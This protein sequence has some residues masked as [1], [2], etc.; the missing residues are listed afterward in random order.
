M[1]RIKNDIQNLS[2][3]KTFFFISVFFMLLATLFSV[4]AMS[5]LANVRYDIYEKYIPNNVSDSDMIRIIYD[6]NFILTPSDQAIL[7]TL[8]FLTP[9]SIPFFYG[10]CI[11]LAGA[12]FYRLKIKKP[13][14]VLKEATRKIANDDLD[15]QIDYQVA[16]D[17]GS[18]CRSFEKMRKDLYNKN[19]E[20]WRMMEE[21]KRVNAAFAH[22]LRTPLTVLRGYTD[23]LLRYVPTGQIS[24]EKLLDTVALM[25]EH[26]NRLENYVNTMNAVQ[27]LEDIIV[28]PQDI[29]IPTFVAQIKNNIKILAE[30]SEK[31]YEIHNQI[32]EFLLHFDDKIVLQVLDNLAANAFRYA[33]SMVRIECSVKSNYLQI[34]VS[35]DGKGFSAEDLKSA[36]KPFY[37]D[38]SATDKNHF[39]LGLNICK[40][41]C[42]KHGGSLILMNN[43][44]GGAKVVA[45][46]YLKVSS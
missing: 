2:I 36:T 42:E 21:R 18:L 39:G 37:K 29:A 33:Q 17:L 45:N 24:E 1:G 38:L 11:I 12:L 31:N 14:V 13:I 43:A 7:N 30:Q 25:S 44:L 10:I 41:L 5:E 19:K 35:D 3:Q 20:M 8:D 22:D 6:Y 40:I 4:L 16:D 46:F 23:F 9:I 26:I 15:F 34:T 27:R 32:A 28:Q